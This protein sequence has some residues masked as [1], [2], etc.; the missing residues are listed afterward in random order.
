MLRQLRGILTSF[1]SWQKYAK[2]SKC[3][4]LTNTANTISH[5]RQRDAKGLKCKLATVFTD[6]APL[7]NPPC[8]I[9]F[10]HQLIV[11]LQI[12][13]WFNLFQ[14]PHLIFISFLLSPFAA[15]AFRLLSPLALAA[16]RRLRV[17]CGGASDLW[18]RAKEDAVRRRR[19]L[20]TAAKRERRGGL[21][22]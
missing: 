14:F 7:H 18:R 3:V 19:R 13:E 21:P 16:F 9:I 1:L 4:F 5:F 6:P 8:I 20:G 15:G 12:V 2:I 11:I 10:F 17:A 22:E